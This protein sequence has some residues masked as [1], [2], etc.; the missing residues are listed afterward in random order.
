MDSTRSKKYE[1]TNDIQIV[2]QDTKT[3]GSGQDLPQDALHEGQHEAVRH[4]LEAEAAD[5]GPQEG[6]L[7]AALFGLNE[8]LIPIPGD[9]M[10][11][12]SLVF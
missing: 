9:G 12:S 6:G 3:I 2:R 4:H 10:E 1:D 11:C 8:L 7:A 5:Q